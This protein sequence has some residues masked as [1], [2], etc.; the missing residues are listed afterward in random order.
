MG[1]TTDF[2]GIIT[3]TPALTPAQTEYL[4]AFMR[5]RHVRRDPA[6][7]ATMPDPLRAAVGLGLGY[8]SE[9]YVGSDADVCTPTSDVLDI[10]A[11]PATQPGL[12]C[13]WEIRKDGSGLQ[14]NGGEKFYRYTEWLEYLIK[15][16]FRPW[17]YI[18]QGEIEWQGE[19]SAD[20][21]TIFVKDNEVEAIRDVRLKGRPSWED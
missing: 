16:F 8:E 13:D 17:L 11:P 4:N 6:I 5:I 3:I 18:L 15:H 2:D 7:T 20:S 9:Y 21:G 12:W 1:Y 19:D 10:N 14:W